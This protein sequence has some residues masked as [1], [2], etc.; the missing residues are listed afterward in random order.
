VWGSGVFLCRAKGSI[1]DKRQKK[2][3]TAEK[4][5]VKRQK[6][7]QTAEKAA[8]NRIAGLSVFR[9]AR[10]KIEPFAAV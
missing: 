4:M 10:N 8:N 9:R 6:R 5:P 3:Q 7:R 1:F 2:R